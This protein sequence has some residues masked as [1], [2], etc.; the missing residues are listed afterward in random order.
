MYHLRVLQRPEWGWPVELGPEA[1]VVSA[2]PRAGA[3]HLRSLCEM[4]R[5]TVIRLAQQVEPGSMLSWTRWNGFSLE[6]KRVCAVL[7]SHSVTYRGDGS[8]SSRLGA[9]AIH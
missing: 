3:G 6:E 8:S 7:L 2:N 5:A 9:S 1:W 4:L